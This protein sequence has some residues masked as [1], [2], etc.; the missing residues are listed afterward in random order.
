MSFNAHIRPALEDVMEGIGASP[1]GIELMAK[2]GR[3]YHIK[4][5]N[6]PLKDAIILKQEALA[7]G[8]D[9]AVSWGVVGLSTDTT[10]ALLII[11]ERQAEILIRKMRYQPF[12]GN[13]IA[14]EVEEAIRNYGKEPVFTVRGKKIDFPAVMGILNVTPDSFSD[15]GKYDRPEKAIE[16]ALE[17]AEEGAAI[18]D[19]GGE[20]SRPGS[21][22]I[23]AEEELDR[24]LPVIE[25]IRE[26][27][28]V[29]ISVDTYKPEVAK[30]ALHAGADIIN[31]IY[32]LRME[33][34]AEVI[35][36]HNAS[37]VIMHMQG[38]PENMQDN[39]QYMDVIGEITG[40]LRAQAEKALDAGISPDAIAVDPGIGFGKTVEH[41]LTIIRELSSFRSLGYPVLLGASRKSFIGKSLGLEVDERL[42]ASLAVA[43]IGIWN[44]ASII[45]AHD[46]KETM[47]AVKMA[48]EIRG[49]QD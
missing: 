34:M 8:G 17:M 24:I 32:G 15:G 26:E 37:V 49:F 36:D 31:D 7:V 5:E 23:S 33:G 40:F 48:V 21:P 18:I 12:N 25:E 42:E 45:R 27:S 20:S 14:D 4:L 38:D 11:T 28:D 10:D 43:A 22:R 9:C 1:E 44:G 39:P 46:V 41:N 47:R 3:M 30:K 6:V 2:K 13:R 29:L 19:I 16:R 35:A